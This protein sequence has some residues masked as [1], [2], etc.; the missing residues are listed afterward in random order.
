MSKEELQKRSIHSLEFSI[1]NGT[2]KT[3]HAL[4]T[5]QRLFC[6]HSINWNVNDDFYLNCEAKWNDYEGKKSSKIQ[7]KAGQ[8]LLSMIWWS[9]LRKVRMVLANVFV[10]KHFFPQCVL[11][12]FEWHE[13]FEMFTLFFSKITLNMSHNVSSTLLQSIPTEKTADYPKNVKVR[14]SFSTDSSSIYNPQSTVNIE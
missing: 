10:S 9:I 13:L 1:E 14:F 3:Y 5:A 11:C 4:W 12:I 6:F 2:E 8:H 7:F